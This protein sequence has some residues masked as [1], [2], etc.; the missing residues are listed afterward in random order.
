MGETA[1]IDN[2]DD[3]ILY[4]WEEMNSTKRKNLEIPWQLGICASMECLHAIFVVIIVVVAAGAVVDPAAAA[5]SSAIQKFWIP[6]RLGIE[7]IDAQLPS[8]AIKKEEK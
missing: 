6:W 4:I 5:A 1:G 2:E 3:F 8:D 7:T